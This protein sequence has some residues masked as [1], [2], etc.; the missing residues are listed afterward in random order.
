[1][2]AARSS[3]PPPE[4]YPSGEETAPPPDTPTD[5]PPPP[6]NGE[7]GMAEAPPLRKWRSGPPPL[8]PQPYRIP[9]L[10]YR[11]FIAGL[12]GLGLVILLVLIPDQ[13]VYTARYYGASFQ[14]PE[15][16]LVGFGA[17]ISLLSPLAYILKP[18]RLYGPIFAVK[19]LLVL[20]YLLVLAN[21]AYLTFIFP[22]GEATA[23]FGFVA[24]VTL[25]AIIPALKLVSALVTTAEDLKDP[26][27]RLPFD[28]PPARY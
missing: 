17:G 6:A 7:P 26:K 11:L 28:F 23:T 21:V 1:M 2:T 8:V 13:L 22:H 25:V 20:L 16:E 14:L 4:P 19:S 27:E 24:L 9:S 10:T 5:L 18:T 15:G 12:M 3:L